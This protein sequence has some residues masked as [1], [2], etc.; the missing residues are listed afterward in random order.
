[1][2]RLRR[3]E[4]IEPA[5][6]GRAVPDPA[7]ASAGS[8]AVE[9]RFGTAEAKPAVLD[10]SQG[11]PFV[12][13]RTCKG[14]SHVTATVCSRCDARLDT[15][16]QRAFNQAFWTRRQAEDAELRAETERLRAS[17]EQ[18]DRDVSEARKAMEWMDQEIA[19]RRA[20]RITRRQGALVISF[21][22]DARALGLAVGRFLRRAVR[23]AR[24]ILLRDPGR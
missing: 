20:R 10:L 2:S 8:E 3:F 16:E 21:E 19:L 1:M 5:G 24:R 13:C 22:P 9:G 15:R 23:A 12:R 17:R 18:A 7:P 11:Q 6:G 4:Q 14:D